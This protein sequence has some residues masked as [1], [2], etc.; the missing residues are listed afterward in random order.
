MEEPMTKPAW[1]GMPPICFSRLATSTLIALWS[2]AVASGLYL[3]AAYV[4]SDGGLGA[5]PSATPASLTLDPDRYSLVMAVHPECPCTRASLGE[6][7]RLRAKLGDRLALS[8]LVFAPGAHADTWLPAFERRLTRLGLE[9]RVIADPDGAIAAGLGCRTSGSVVMYAPDGTARFWG[10]ITAARGHHG[11][12]LGSDAV[13]AVVRD[14]SQETFTDARLRLHHHRRAPRGVLL[15]RGDAMTTPETLAR[16]DQIAD[17]QF[18]RIR[19]RTNRMFGALLLI[20]FVAVVAAAF[21]ITPFTWEGAERTINFHVYGAIAIG[22]AL[23]SLPVYFA[24][25]KSHS[26]VTQHVVSCAQVMYSSL[27]IHISGGRIETHFH[28]F[29]SLAFVAFYRD[30][31][32]LILPTLLVAA[33]HVAR[34]IFWPQ[35]V[36]GVL[37]AAPWRAAEHAGWVIIEDIVLVYAC[38]TSSRDVHSI[39]G[40]QA[41]LEAS[42]DQMEEQVQERTRHLRE[43]LARN[44]REIEDRKRLEGQLVQAQ[45]LESIGQLAAG[46]AHEINTPAQYV[47]DN[48]RFVRSELD[49][50]MSVIDAY[51]KEL[52]PSAREKSWDTRAADI[53]QQLERVD[54]AFLRTEIPSALD[55]S[56]EGIDRISHIVKAMKEFSHP[57]KNIKEP[58]NLNQ[59]IESTVTVCSN[60]WKYAADVTMDLDPHLPTLPCLLGEFNQVILNLVVNAADAIETRFKGQDAKGAIAVSTEF[61]ETHAIIRVTDNGGG[62][63]DDVREKIFDPFF[64]TKEVGKG[65]GQGLAISRS[66]IVDKHGGELECESEPGEGTTFIVKLPFDIPPAQ[67]RRMAA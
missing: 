43:A 64:T 11:D 28:I 63:P 3:Q 15:L 41:R 33:D 10:G 29:S 45:K 14:G 62:I 48:T 32:T 50:L 4:Q 2:V 26:R 7:Q 12:N 65:T 40:H 23:S 60:R 24:F 35:S 34:G 47:A 56:L 37:V 46:I 18:M 44:V 21:V 6:L 30:W 53:K 9:G 54:Y 22:A 25:F 51:E 58:A 5:P 16:A 55:Q 49:N 36:F 20:E 42:K 38:V 27:L 17:E 8:Y 59:A 39:A 31:R 13:L 1:L 52:D 66:V 67:A 61:D 19:V 57:G